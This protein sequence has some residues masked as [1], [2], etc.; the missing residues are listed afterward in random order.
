M[1]TVTHRS[2][3]GRLRVWMRLSSF[4]AVSA[5]VSACASS[6]LET[7]EMRTLATESPFPRSVSIA[8]D[9]AD[10][11]CFGEASEW[12]TDL[13]RA[14]RE[15][16]VCSAVW[17]EAERGA[18]DADM[19]VSV[20]LERLLADDP[21][22]GQPEVDTQ[23]M[24]VGV[25]S[26]MFV[27][28][29]P[30]WIADVRIDPGLQIGLEWSL[31]PSGRARGR[32]GGATLEAD[33]IE[34][35]L[36]ERRPWMA[37]STLGAVFA[38]PLVFREIDEAHLQHSLAERVRAQVAAKIAG[39]I[40]RETLVEREL[41]SGLE[42]TGAASSLTLQYRSTPDLGRLYVWLDESDEK[43]IAIDVAFSDDPTVERHVALRDHLPRPARSGELLRLEALRRDGA[44]FRYSLRTG[45][46]ELSS[47]RT[48]SRKEE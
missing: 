15:L 12:S 43:G 26:W 24:F 19:H 8:I 35:S 45:G 11:T 40:K 10:S 38:P 42:V 34:T 46:D 47:D 36:R 25:V 20:R 16:N 32:R 23:G 17:D 29:L 27:P 1:K 31:H 9:C 30:L 14:F 28:L 21:R 33:S 6:P 13:I 48:S 2:G 5:L 7:P 37:W 44:V 41:L 3:S 22:V 39:A 18:G 4:V